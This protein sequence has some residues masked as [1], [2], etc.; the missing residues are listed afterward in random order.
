MEKMVV[1]YYLVVDGRWKEVGFEI[2]GRGLWL[3]EM[4]Y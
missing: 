2:C 3:L 4:K 1:V